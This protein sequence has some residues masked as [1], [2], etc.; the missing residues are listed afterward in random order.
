MI[1]AKTDFEYKLRRFFETYPY[2]FN[3]K[4]LCVCLSGGADS[5]ALLRGMLNIAEE[6]NVI[7]KACHFNHGIRG[8]EADEDEL[9]CKSLCKSLGVELFCGRDNVPA[10]AMLHKMSLEEAARDRRY[11]FFYR[12]GEKTTVDFCLTAHNMNDDAETLIYNLIRGSG[13][14]GACGISLS[15]GLTLRPM[16]KIERREVEAY[17]DFLQQ[18]YVTDST[19]LSNDYTRNFIRHEIIPQMQKINPSVIQALTRFT[20]S[21]RNDRDYFI[22]L[23]FGY[24]L[25]DIRKHPK[26]I[27]DRIII[28]K[29][30]DTIDIHLNSDMVER[31]EKALFSGRR[32]TV[33]LTADAEAIVSRG[34]VKF[35]H[36]IEDEEFEFPP[37]ALMMDESQYMFGRVTLSVKEES[38]ADESNNKI[39][40]SNVI[41]LDNVKGTV[42][43]RNRRIGDKICIRG[44]NRSLKKMFIEKKIPREYRQ[45]VPIIYDDEGILYVPF[46]GISDRAFPKDN[47]KR[48]KITTT[49]DTVDKERWSDAYEK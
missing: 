29:A 24:Y 12:M 27:R 26:A 45:V 11:A 40:A 33:P 9:F 42:Y 38:S 39:F 36:K 1:P 23:V 3:G 21:T 43:V 18:D 44:I 48:Y 25:D 35:V 7:I 49:L 20:E 46:I 37:E 2:D 4:I 28:N 6:L 14:N 34:R 8:Q 31:I 32:K 30:Y 10:F 5:V 41:T 17:L 47:A 13:V 22:P 19:N 16:L 15:Y